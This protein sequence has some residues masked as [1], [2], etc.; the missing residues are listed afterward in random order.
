MS[1]EYN[2]ECAISISRRS[3]CHANINK[4]GWT[5]KDKTNQRDTEP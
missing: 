1:I 5:H 2:N 3:E 4:T